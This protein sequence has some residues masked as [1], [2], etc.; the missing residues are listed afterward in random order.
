VTARYVKLTIQSNWGGYIAAVRLE[1]GA[2]PGCAGLGEPDPPTAATD[3]SP[4]TTLELAAGTRGGNPR[5]M[6]RHGSTC[7]SARDGH[8]TIYEASLD[9]DGDLLLESQQESTR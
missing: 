2:F 4:A 9:L 8:G 6:S 7:W 1:R 5:G 3:L